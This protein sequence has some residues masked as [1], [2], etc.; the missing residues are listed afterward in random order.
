MYPI[1][2][3]NLKFFTTQYV[4]SYLGLFIVLYQQQSSI[5]PPLNR[6]PILFGAGKLEAGPPKS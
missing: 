3:H 1:P 5:V 2:K 4:N 6:I